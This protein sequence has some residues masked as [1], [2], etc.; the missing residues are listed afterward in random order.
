MTER[1][2]DTS[3]CS[4]QEIIEINFGASPYVKNA[5]GVPYS[6][7]IIRIPKTGRLPTIGG[8]IEVPAGEAGDLTTWVNLQ[9][10][11]IRGGV[12]QIDNYSES[13]RAV[14]QRTAVNDLPAVKYRIP[15][16]GIHE[17]IA[18]WIGVRDE[19]VAIYRNEWFEGMEGGNDELYLGPF[20]LDAIVSQKIL[21]A[22]NLTP[23]VLSL[24]NV[25]G[26]KPERLQYLIRN[27]YARTLLLE[28]NS[29]GVCYLDDSTDDEMMRRVK[30]KL[31][32]MNLTFEDLNCDQRF[33]LMVEAFWEM[34]KEGL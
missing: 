22:Y 2:K 1:E 33:N 24:E 15:T 10:S 3:E 6:E 19:W 11:W 23:G 13:V 8:K 4:H 26:T 25:G 29:R 20:A 18:L 14:P 17:I 30:G 7:N 32:R 12:I 9:E 31:D 34:D 21:Q 5:P 28:G 27:Q 16:K